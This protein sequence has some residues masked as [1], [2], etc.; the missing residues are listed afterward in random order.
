[1]SLRANAVSVFTL[2]LYGRL[3]A[4]LLLGLCRGVKVP[5]PGYPCLRA[6]DTMDTTLQAVELNVFGFPS[7]KATLLL[8]PQRPTES[9]KQPVAQQ[10]M[11]MEM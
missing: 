7:R 9:E 6:Y 2:P 10:L 4:N 1:M 8:K 11:R 5:S 3:M